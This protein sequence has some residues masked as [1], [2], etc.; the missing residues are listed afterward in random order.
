MDGIHP[1]NSG[2]WQN[3]E[4]PPRRSVSGAPETA[5]VR[6]TYTRDQASQG[7]S[8]ED[9]MREAREKIDSHRKALEK[10]KK[11]S[12]IRYGDAPMTAYARLAGAKTKAQV[13]AAAGYARRRIAQFREIGRAAG[14]ER[15]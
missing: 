1:I 13:T 11:R 6:D 4:T 12:P 9:L 14:G 7:E 8:L 2:T 3:S 5:P 10:M 15:V